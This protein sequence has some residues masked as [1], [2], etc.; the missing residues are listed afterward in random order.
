MADTSGK[1]LIDSMA[2]VKKLGIVDGLKIADFGCGRTGH[3][4]FPL[5]KAVGDTGVVYAVDI[6]KD[7]LASIDSRV[8]SEGYHNVHTVWSDIEKYG[9]TPIP[10]GSLDAIFFVNVFSLLKDSASAIRE[11]GRLLTDTGILVIIDWEKK[12]GAL[13]PAADHLIS[14]SDFISLAAENNFK[15]ASQ[16]SA[17]DYHFCL[18]FIK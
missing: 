9:A 7:I 15:M 18:T 1:A 8:R 10:A 13:G 3:F 16:F 4:V 12:L 2:I 6:I 17:G 14:P 11:A 5:S